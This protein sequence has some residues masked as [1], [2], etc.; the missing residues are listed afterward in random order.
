MEI[1]RYWAPV[2]AAWNRMKAVLFQPFDLEKWMVMGF[3]A[4]FSGL[5][6]GG[7]SSFNSSNFR[8]HEGGNL[9]EVMQQFW[10]QYSTVIL[11]VGGGLL[12]A[13]IVFGILFA[14]LGARG[15]FIFLDNALHISAP[16]LSLYMIVID[17]VLVFEYNSMF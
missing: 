8:D 1:I 6:S 12:L 15:R 2:G 11:A 13:F 17:L 3:V 4:W 7:G 9:S 16:K 14:W 10:T 5:N